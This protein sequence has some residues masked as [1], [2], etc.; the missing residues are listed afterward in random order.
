MVVWT[1]VFDLGNKIIIYP[2]LALRVCVNSVWDIVMSV[3]LAPGNFIL[4]HYS[5]DSAD[6]IVRF[7][8][9]RVR[10]GVIKNRIVVRAARR[11]GR[12]AG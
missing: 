8:V 9:A 10:R 1:S 6:G 3:N 7:G 5:A 2:I 12:I 4:V 11:I